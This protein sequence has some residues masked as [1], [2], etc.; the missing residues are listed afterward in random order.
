MPKRLLGRVLDRRRRI[1]KPETLF[2]QVLVVS[3]AVLES[4]S[5]LPVEL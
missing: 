2:E 5:Q 4:H 1:L 3:L